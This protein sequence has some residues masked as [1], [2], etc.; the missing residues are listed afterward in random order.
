M[1][2]LSGSG[3]EVRDRF[4][5]KAENDSKVPGKMVKDAE[6]RTAFHI[7]IAK[8]LFEISVLLAWVGAGRKS[9]HIQKTQESFVKANWTSMDVQSQIN[10]FNTSLT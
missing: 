2:F 6:D 8:H 3:K 9:R 1:D 10:N 7:Y 4:E 5:S